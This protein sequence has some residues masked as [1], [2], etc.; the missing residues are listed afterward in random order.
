MFG[1]AQRQRQ[2]DAPAIEFDPV[3]TAHRQWP[4]LD[5]LSCEFFHVRRQQALVDLAQVVLRERMLFDRHE[6]QALAAVRAV[7]PGLP[8]GKKVQAQPEA[9]FQDDEA[10]PRRPA[11]RQAVAS[12]EYVMCLRQRTF[13]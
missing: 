13:G 10:F 8:G 6:V 4:A 5:Q 9:R 3:H 7:A 11:R 12:E 2:D 1:V